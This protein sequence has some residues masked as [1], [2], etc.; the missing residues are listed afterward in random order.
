[1]STLFYF[2]AEMQYFHLDKNYLLKEAQKNKKDVLLE[3][4]VLQSIEG[5]MITNNPMGLVDAFIERVS[6]VTNYS[7]DFLSDT[8][9]LLA[10]SYRFLFSSNQ[11]EFL[12]DGSSHF[13]KYS[14]EWETQFNHWIYG[15]CL[16]DHINRSI[17]KTCVLKENGNHLLLEK[18]FSRLVLLHLNLKW[19]GRK[20]LL[21]RVA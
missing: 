7:T 9:D 6:G 12:W 8:Y 2:C 13:L 17:L 4:W 19:D 5:Y 21:E 3:K 10:A 15:L 11:L 18:N 20:K 1:M 14:E 16:Q